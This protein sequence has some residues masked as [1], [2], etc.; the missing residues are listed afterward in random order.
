MSND[1]LMLKFMASFLAICLGILLPVA[2]MPLRVCL[3]E[4]TERSED[5]CGTC[6]TS[7]KHCCVDSEGLP[8][9]LLPAGNYEAPAFVAYPLPPRVADLPPVPERI[10]PPPAH[11]RAPT[12]MGPPTAR[13]AVLNVWRL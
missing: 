3:L 12:G 9:S 7:D 11:A 13:L 2:A 10:L 4:Q 6:S 1:F 5:C 8:D